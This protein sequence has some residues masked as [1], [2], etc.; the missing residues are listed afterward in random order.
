MLSLPLAACA[1][2]VAERHPNG[3]LVLGGAVALLSIALALVLAWRD[4]RAL[5]ARHRAETSDEFQ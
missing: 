3:F 4:Q 5:A 1:V 2:C